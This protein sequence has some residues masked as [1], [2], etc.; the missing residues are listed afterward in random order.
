MIIGLGCDITNI[1]RICKSFKFIDHFMQRICGPEEIA[2]ISRRQFQTEQ[3]KAC[4]LAKYFAGK[5]AFAKALGTGFRDGIFL[6]DVQILH[7]PLGK[8]FLQISGT[9]AI[10]L[11]ELSSQ[12][13]THISLS[14]DFPYAQAVVIIEC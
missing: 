6:K 14:D 2:E 13:Q 3:E 12:A 8:P 1:D 10:K 7:N 5:E 11:A 4:L 9:A